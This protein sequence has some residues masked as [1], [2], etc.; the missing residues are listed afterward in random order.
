MVSA[1][2]RK[3]DVARYG[4]LLED[5]FRLG[6]TGQKIPFHSVSHDIDGKGIICVNVVIPFSPNL[7]DLERFIKSQLIVDEKRSGTLGDDAS[8]SPSALR[9]VARLGPSRSKLPE[10]RPFEGKTFHIHVDTALGDLLQKTLEHFPEYASGEGG[11]NPGKKDLQLLVSCLEEALAALYLK[12]SFPFPLED[13]PAGT[14]PAEA[15]YAGEPE[16]EETPETGKDPSDPEGRPEPETKAH[17]KADEMSL[18]AGELLMFF[19]TRGDMLDRWWSV[20]SESGLDL[21][22]FDPKTSGPDSPG[23]RDLLTLFH[24]RGLADI[25]DVAEYVDGCL[26]RWESL[27]ASLETARIRGKIPSG[28]MTVFEFAFALLSNENRDA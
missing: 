22:E 7:P 11:E 5:I 12:E 23:F 17:E 3:D 1:W 6:L 9:Y 19:R 24:N 8:G 13:L 14:P 2:A 4:A 15:D 21:A 28:R 26:G 27:Y 10:W 20:A 16:L 25:R 18:P